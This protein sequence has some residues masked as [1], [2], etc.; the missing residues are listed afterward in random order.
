MGIRVIQKE[1]PQQQEHRGISVAGTPSPLPP[2]PSTLD[3]AGRT[4]PQGR[5]N[6]KLKPKPVLQAD[7]PR[8]ILVRADGEVQVP[9]PAL[10]RQP[11]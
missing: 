10:E 2:F 6:L 1:S 11:V 7:L 3:S 9:Q 8:A 4:K 5:G